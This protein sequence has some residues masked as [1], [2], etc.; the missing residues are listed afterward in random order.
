MEITKEGYQGV[1]FEMKSQWDG[2]SLASMAMPGGS[3]MTATDR[4]TGSDLAFYPL[5][6][7]NL[8]NQRGMPI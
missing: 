5:P 7:S 4:A 8:K 3:L 2:A 1:K 6:K